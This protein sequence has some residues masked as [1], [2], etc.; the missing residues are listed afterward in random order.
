MNEFSMHSF[1]YT[2]MC[3]SNKT[4][5]D[6]QRKEFELKHLKLKKYA[7]KELNLILPSNLHEFEWGQ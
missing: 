3:K 6:E 1:D 5:A 2:I 7:E 4:D